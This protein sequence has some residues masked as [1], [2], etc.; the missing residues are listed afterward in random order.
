MTQGS[1]FDLPAPAAPDLPEGLRYESGFLDARAESALIDTIRTLP[2][3]A[4]RY[5]QYTAR[6]RV[7]SFGWSFD[8]S[9]NTLERAPGTIEPLQALRDRVAR[10]AGLRPESLVQ[11]LLT[12]Y[13][14]GTPL[15]WHRDAPDFGVVIGLSLG[16]SARLRFRPYPHVAHRR[17]EVTVL[18]AAP[19][20][21]YLMRGPA[22]WHWQHS[23]APVAALRWSITFRTLRVSRTCQ[24][25][26]MRAAS[27][28]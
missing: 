2:L 13:P 9:T 20:S 10:W 3:A 19:R 5:R 16:S 22:R 7:L 4:A 24:D 11:T 17:S 8:F 12:E 28:P 1:L 21:V 14:P 25:G 23:V 27:D 15:G 6:R 26:S 18:D